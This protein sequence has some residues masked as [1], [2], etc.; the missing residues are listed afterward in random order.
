MTNWIDCK[1]FKPPENMDVIIY[2]EY[3][4]DFKNKS[5][6]FVS[7]GFYYIYQY[8]ENFRGNTI[9]SNSIIINRPLYWTL[10]LKEPNCDK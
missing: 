1:K 2:F 4:V 9:R 3:D 8:E 10:P 7:E 5:V 6:G